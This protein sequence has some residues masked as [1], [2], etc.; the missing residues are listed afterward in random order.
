MVN[1]GG[2]LLFLGV[3]AISTIALVTGMLVWEARRPSRRATA[4]AVARGLPCDP[5]ELG[6]PYEAW[7]LER[8]GAVLPVWEI[9]GERAAGPTVIL[10]HGWGQA[11][12]DMLSRL[13]VWR[14][15]AARVVVYDLR[16]H[17]TAEGGP[18]RLT[19]GEED[20]LLALLDRLGDGPFLLVGQSL[21]SVIALAAAADAADRRV[22]GVVAYAPFI[23]LGASIRV[24][25]RRQ[26]LPTWP[27]VGL[28][29]RWLRLVG[30]RPRAATDVARGLACPLLV[31]HGTDDPVAPVDGARAVTDA[32]PDGEL[33]LIEGG[34][35]GDVHLVAPD[36]HDDAIR[37]FV[38]RVGASEVIAS[39]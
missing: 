33:V 6:V 23:D 36:V 39:A 19:S 21:G 12:V 38:A 3:A 11:R 15:L 35:H 4:Y 14:D 5:G 28:A 7:Q 24:R 16:G 34:A 13:A 27:I 31:V 22:V 26:G 17:G 29:M 32:A 30:V 1:V 8:P 20:D 25:M 10:V 18:S 9:E 2:L 37:R